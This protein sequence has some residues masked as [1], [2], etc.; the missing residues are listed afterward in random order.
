MPDYGTFLFSDRQVPGEKVSWRYSLRNAS[1]F[2]ALPGYGNEGG[3]RQVSS[4]DGNLHSNR[5]FIRLLCGH[6]RLA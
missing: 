2:I 3:T 5:H 6:K 4:L 1:A